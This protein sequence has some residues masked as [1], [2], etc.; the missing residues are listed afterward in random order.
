[1]KKNENDESDKKKYKI[2]HI[3]EVNKNDKILKQ[4][5]PFKINIIGDLAVGK[6]SISIRAIKNKFDY[7]NY[8]PTVN[9]DI[10][11][12]VL[13]IED[14]ILPLFFWDTCGQE[15]FCSLTPSLFK[16]TSIVCIVYA[17]NDRK[18]Y[19]NIKKWVSIIKNDSSNPD[20][21]I[22]LIGNKCDLKGERAVTIEE[23]EQMKINYGFSYFTEVSA[24]SGFNIINLV[25]KMGTDIYEEYLMKD[26][27]SSGSV[28]LKKEDLRRNSEYQKKKKD[29]EKCC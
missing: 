29:K 4:G 20:V 27:V 18:S 17:I 14:N 24:K 6:T 16:G 28:K 23:G 10:F 12:Y 5:T 9:V 19:E 3:G 7:N 26:I 15:K 1:M 25:E 11:N 13:K 2:K 22:F 21:I 8:N